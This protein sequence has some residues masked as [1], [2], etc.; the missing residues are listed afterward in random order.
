MTQMRVMTS[1]GVTLTYD[2]EDVE[3]IEV[4]VLSEAVEIHTGPG[5]AVRREL[6][7]YTQLH[8]HVEFK[9]GKRPLWVKNAELD[10]DRVR[11]ELSRAGDILTTALHAEDIPA[12]LASRIL[13]RF[14]F[15][16]PAGLETP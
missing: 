5:R 14:L 4:S 11:R 8:L 3:N 16:N 13:N 2:T 6:T 7:G 15:G 1:N 10:G 9:H 12:E